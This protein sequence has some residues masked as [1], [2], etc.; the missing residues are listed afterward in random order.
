MSQLYN[1]N[2]NSNDPAAPPQKKLKR[3]LSHTEYDKFISIITKLD[4]AHGPVLFR[5]LSWQSEYEILRRTL[6]DNR[7]ISIEYGST[8]NYSLFFDRVMIFLIGAVDIESQ[9]ELKNG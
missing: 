3:S 9:T 7:H 1:N 8:I 2:N 6:F 4:K 5:C